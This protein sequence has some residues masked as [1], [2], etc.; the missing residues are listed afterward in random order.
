MN[1]SRVRCYTQARMEEEH[2]WHRVVEPGRL[3]RKIPA[4]TFI[5]SV[6]LE[7]FRDLCSYQFS[8]L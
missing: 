3:D 8:L 1:Y 2:G 4:S 7:K 6:V 5:Y